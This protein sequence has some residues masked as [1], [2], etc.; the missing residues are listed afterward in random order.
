MSF[1]GQESLSSTGQAHGEFHRHSRRERILSGEP[2]AAARDV[3]RLPGARFRDA[4]AVEHFVLHFL[5][6]VKTALD[7]PLALALMAQE[8][9]RRSC[10]SRLPPHNRNYTPRRRRLNTSLVTTTVL[11]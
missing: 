1:I 3:D 2:N 5:L 8:F 9:S 11:S 7:P 6:D 10:Q 4:L